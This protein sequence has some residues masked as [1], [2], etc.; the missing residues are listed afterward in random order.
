MSLVIRKLSIRLKYMWMS[1]DN[2]INTLLHQESSPLFFVFIWHGFVFCSPVGDEDNAVADFFGLLDHCGD[3]VFVKDI[4]H[5]FVTVADTG[6]IGAICIVKE[7]NLDSI[8]FFY[9]YGI[10]VFL[11][12]VDS[13][14]RNIWIVGAPEIQSVFQVIIAIIIC[15]V[16]SRFYNIKSGFDNGVTNLFGCGK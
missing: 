5:V 16:G 8:D 4:K 7:S 15:V 10:C 3:L 11:S 6:I 14:Y 13:K 1:A 12:G 9:F 2:H